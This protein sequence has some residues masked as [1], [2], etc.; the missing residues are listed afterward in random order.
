MPVNPIPKGFHSITPYLPIKDCEKFLRFVKD[1]FNAVE[2]HRSLTPDGKIMHAEFK[3]GDSMMMVSEASERFPE[4][5]AF[6]YL[7]VNDTDIMYKQALAAGGISEME[8]ANQFYGDRN[9]GVKDSF[10]N[11]WW[12]ATHVEDLS[13]EEIQKRADEYYKNKK[14]AS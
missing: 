3:I 10:G 11:T 4:T 5:K 12:I 6:F 2:I 1:A 9:A 14:Q 8:P 13:D 7:Y